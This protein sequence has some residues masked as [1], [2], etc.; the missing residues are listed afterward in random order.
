MVLHPLA[1][2]LSGVPGVLSQAQPEYIGG[3]GYVSIVKSVILIGV[4]LLW[5]KLLAWSSDDA[6]AAHLP[7]AQLNIANLSGMVAAYAIVFALP[8]SFF[9]VFPIVLL[10]LAAEAAVYLKMRDKVSGLDDLKR[11]FQDW[12]SG[13]KRAKKVD[14]PGA[15]VLMGKGGPMPVPEGT[16]PERLAYDAVQL[17]LTDP[18]RKGADQIDLTPA[19]DGTRVKFLVDLVSY[20]L[21]TPLDAAAGP[22]AV[23]YIKEAVGLDPDER[24]KPQSGSLK[25]TVDGEKREAKVQSAG[26]TAGEFVRMVMNPAKRH[27]RKLSELGMPDAQLATVKGAIADRSG[28]VLVATPKGHGL[29]QLAYGLLRGHDAFM[30]HLQSIERDAADG[31]EGVTPNPLA[32]AAP[33]ADEAQKVD[34]VISQA[35]DVIFLDK[36]ESPQSAAALVAYSAEDKRA[37]V[38]VRA[39]S[40]AEAIEAWRRVA[41]AD[42]SATDG[43]KMVIAG[44]VLRK[45]CPACK[46]A[47]SPDPDTLRKL[48]MN[49]DKVKELFKA[50]ETPIRDPKGNPIPCEFCRDLLYKGRTGVFEVLTVTDVILAAIVADGPRLG[51][52][53]KS[54]FRKGKNRYLQEEGLALV[55][56]GET[57][58]QEVLRVLK[59]ADDSVPAAAPAARPPSAPRPPSSG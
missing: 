40:S 58:V 18:L 23:T 3:G 37:Y 20:D 44:R 47:Y 36:M 56:A 13:L 28:V 39:G 7:H 12:K 32:A 59:P 5:C 31:A 8:L 53:F 21:P 42:R 15:V 17:A 6:K 14:A 57:S 43:L 30:E 33:P 26:T 41:G 11:Q 4:L 55:E 24:R 48:N 10:I 54:A 19:A 34:W 16:A 22:A 50:R 2:I 9:L 38:G 27:A 1:A 35:P 25:L 45:L 51:A 46:E 49:P 29:T 52:N